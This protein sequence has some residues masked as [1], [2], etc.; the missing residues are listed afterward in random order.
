MAKAAQVK[1]RPQLE[2]AGYQERA[3]ASNQ[4]RGKTEAI[5]QLRFG[6][7]GEVGGLLALVKKSHRDLQTADHDRI[8][9]ELGDALWYLTTVAVEY[10]SNLQAVGGE[11][12]L[13]LERRLGINRDAVKGKLTFEEFDGLMA[14]SHAKLS[15]DQIPGMLRQLASHCGSLL[16]E[17]GDHDLAAHPPFQTLSALLADL[18]TIGTLFGQRFADIAAANI[19]KVESRWPPEGTTHI[20]LFDEGKSSLEQF[21]RKFAMCFIERETPAG[22]P[23]V[24]QQLSGVN[25]GD[26]LTD[27][28]TEPDGYR[29]HDVFHLAYLVHL[30]WSPVIRALLKLK[31]KSDPDV[32]ENEDGARAMIIE[33]GIATWIFNHAS[34]RDY[35][36]SIEVG[37]LNYGILKQVVD[38]VDGYEVDK[39]PLWQWERAI[40]DGFRVFRQL[41][42]AAGGI[43]EVDLHARTLE[44]RELPPEQLVAPEPKKRP[45]LVGAAPPPNVPPQS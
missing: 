6:F 22:R 38:M 20:P 25:I 35:F 9:E 42:A 1:T 33:E 4:L 24:I 37:R 7:F 3:C 15:K 14:F 31:R 41:Q 45:R 19:A 11:A 17:S 5:D 34:R 2:L 28:R 32:D 29:F 36:E 40:L 10:G 8:T 39:C 13:E 21:P 44:F 27:N 26:R 23:Y 16:S 12:I 30:G 18:V 43:V